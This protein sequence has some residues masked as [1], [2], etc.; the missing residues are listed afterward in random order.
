MDTITI[1][2][3]PSR[4]GLGNPQNGQDK[5]L[6]DLSSTL[7]PQDNID[8]PLPF[9][10]TEDKQHSPTFD[11]TN[12]QPISDTSLNEDH[13]IC[14]A[15]M[16]KL[17]DHVDPPRLGLKVILDFLFALWKIGVLMLSPLEVQFWVALFVTTWWMPWFWT[18][19]MIF[20][21]ILMRHDVVI[22]KREARPPTHGG[23]PED[24]RTPC[25]HYILIVCGSGGHTGEMIRM[26]DRGI[27]PDGLSH[28]RWAIGYGDRMSYDKVVEFE[29]NLAKKHDKKT[30]LGT[31]DIQFF[32]RPRAVHQSWLTTPFTALLSLVEMVNI[33]STKPGYGTS[34]RFRFP[35]VIATD[36]PG[37]GFMFLLA[38]HWLKMTFVIPNGFVKTIYVE[39][40]AR[41]KSL[42]MSGKLVKYFTL[43]DIFIVQWE[44]II[45]RLS[46]NEYY[47][48][49]FVALPGRHNRDHTH[50][51]RTK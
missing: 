18:V 4:E 45:R 50:K 32:H 39:S 1:Q 16:E 40:W 21:P 7:L 49:N 6:S 12:T 24:M 2:P 41:T 13:R 25:P 17:R 43:A 19:A 3:R 34:T 8:P 15:E 14:L 51:R 26:V 46:P 31:F 37:A 9:T 44:G 10:P 11:D 23:W 29:Q 36:G 22:T 5:N 33:M 28:R 47:N 20:I 27:R 42:S 38:A 48:R 30:D 35:G